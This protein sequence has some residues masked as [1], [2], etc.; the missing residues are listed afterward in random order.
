MQWIWVAIKREPLIHF[1][2]IAL[3]LFGSAELLKLKG[4][5]L[6]QE[7]TL[8]VSEDLLFKYIQYQKKTFSP[9][10]AR[11]Y[12]Q[13]LSSSEKAFL[14]DNY[15]HEE[16]LYREAISLGLE[17]NDQII[18]RRLIQKLE[19]VTRGVAHEVDISQN[20]LK[21]YFQHHQERYRL[22]A[23][24]TFTH[25]F[26]DGRKHSAERM[27]VLALQ[28]LE[29]L[30]SKSEVFER[31]SGYG[32]RF[33]F[34]RNYV[35]RTLQLVSSHMGEFLAQQVFTLPLNTWS[36]PFESP[37]GL[38]LVLVTKNTASRLPTFKEAAPMVV[39]D[40]RREK[41]DSAS[42]QKLQKLI[43]RYQIDWG[44]SVPDT[45]MSLTHAE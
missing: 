38:H 24:I 30:R 16:V 29:N 40:Y 2:L 13:G 4:G 21:N 17:K 28:T 27:N 41:M 19:Y 39:E 5:S 45:S 44:V 42:R 6:D 34:H 12:W 15:I 20:A 7:Y 14:I 23:S 11:A 18:R 26:F 9:G 22:E 32:D 33:P 3:M 25:V 31:S 35:E 43:A 8:T 1:L 36:G 10:F 37:Y